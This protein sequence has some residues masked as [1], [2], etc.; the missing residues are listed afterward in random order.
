MV[1]LF[2]FQG[3]LALMFFSGDAGKYTAIE[4]DYLDDFIEDYSPE[5]HYYLIPVLVSRAKYNFSQC[6]YR[7]LSLNTNCMT[8][9]FYILYTF[10]FDCQNIEA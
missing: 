9:P 5:L 6:K 2:N 7:M 4:N 3:V 8:A 1:L 10:C